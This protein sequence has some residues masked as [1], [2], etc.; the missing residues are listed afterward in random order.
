MSGEPAASP[1]PAEQAEARPIKP[2]STL[3]SGAEFPK[4][5]T[6]Q[7]GTQIPVG[8]PP[9]VEPA[10]GKKAIEF[11]KA[12]PE[13][14]QHTMKQVN[15]VLQNPAM[16]QQIFRMQAMMSTPEYQQQMAVLKEDP[17]LKGMFDEIKKGGPE[18]IDKYWND[19]DLM[20][21]ISKKMAALKM[22]AENGQK[23]EDVKVDSLEAAA[24][25]GDAKAV[26]KYI[27]EGADV[28]KKD[29]RGITPLGVAVGF[30]RIDAVKELLAGGA[31]VSL[32]DNQGNTAL[33]Y[34]AGYGRV[35]C[36]EMLMKGGAD[37][38]SMNKN[39]QT[40]L[41]V[42]ELNRETVMIEFL[43]KHTHTE[44]KYV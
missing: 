42:A 25:V 37:P 17:E 34:A 5:I 40:P 32:T 21:K 8:L 3:E 44:D 18:A 7:D 27:A 1:A 11:L 33:H 29:S 41:D 38:K 28:N 20:S 6:L 35:E 31:D 24:K 22:G 26:K 2:K 36:A 9:G 43:K 14:A 12:N 30:N 39:N 13:Y 10:Q 4:S 23:Q 19:M 15:R 16:A